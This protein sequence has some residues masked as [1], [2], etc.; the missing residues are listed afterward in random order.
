MKTRLLCI[1]LVLALVML[2]A[3]CA[4]DSTQ[5]ESAGSAESQTAS[6]ESQTASAGGETAQSESKQIGFVLGDMVNQFYLQMM[7]GGDQAAQDYGVEVLW[8]SCDGSVEKEVNLVENFILQK[9]DFICM[10]PMD[11]EGVVGV[12]EKCAEAGIPCI[13]AANKVAGDENW[14]TLYPDRENMKNTTMALCHALDG[15]GD[16]GMI[17]GAAGSWVIGQREL[18]FQD[19]VDE[20]PNING[21]IQLTNWDVSMV[22]TITE[23]W[24]NTNENFKGIA[25]ALDQYV[26]ASVT[27]AEAI[28]KKD[29]LIW[30]GYDGNK[31]NYDYIN[32]GTQL[33]DQFTGGYR[34]GYWNIAVAARILNGEDIPKDVYLKCH[35]IMSDDTASMLSGKGY[36]VEYITPEEAA[37]LATDCYGEFG[38]ELSTSDFVG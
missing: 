12:V 16:I 28:D 21:D 30:V 7:E 23:N 29:D 1:L 15:E 37:V 36:E 26:L 2:L 17:S 22:P 31:E 20:F 14:C 19:A 33:V 6:A 32:D 13:T 35:Q 8:Q 11:A 24:V 4:G 25:C 3:A 38:P 27:A 5:S 9:V 10:D 34:V 18:G